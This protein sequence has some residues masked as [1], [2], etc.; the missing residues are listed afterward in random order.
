MGGITSIFRNDG[1][2]TVTNGSNGDGAK[3]SRSHLIQFIDSSFV[4]PKEKCVIDKEVKAAETVCTY[5]CQGE[6]CN[7]NDAINE[8]VKSGELKGLGVKQLT[9]VI[10]RTISDNPDVFPSSDLGGY[11]FQSTGRSY[12]L[13]Q[14]KSAGLNTAVNRRYGFVDLTEVRRKLLL[15]SM[16]QKEAQEDNFWKVATGVSIAITTGSLVLILRKIK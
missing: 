15:E 4:F 12:F 11:V 5:S 3:I 2:I 9:E 1:G 6:I 10:V 13:L 16:R 7:F 14:N 8:V